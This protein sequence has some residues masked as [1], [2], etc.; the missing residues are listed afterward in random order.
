MRRII[1]GLILF[2]ISLSWSEATAHCLCWI[3]QGVFIA[4]GCRGL[5]IEMITFNVDVQNQWSN[6]FN[7]NKN[8]KMY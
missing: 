7:A 6:V 2:L 5:A 8:Y 3:K 4:R 1:L